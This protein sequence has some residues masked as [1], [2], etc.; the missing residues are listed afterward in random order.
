MRALLAPNRPC[1]HIFAY[2]GG[3]H[4]SIKDTFGYYKTDQAKNG[5]V[6]NL[7]HDMGVGSNI[8]IMIVGQSTLPQHVMIRKRA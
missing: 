5:G 7:M 3:A 8:Y 2:T 4:N 6:M 1:G